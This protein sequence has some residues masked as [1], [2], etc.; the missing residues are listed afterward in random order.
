MIEHGTDEWYEAR[1][2]LITGSR[3]LDVMTSGRSKAEVW[4][5]RALTYALQL[6]TERITGER[7]VSADSAAT[8]HGNVHEAYAIEE[9]ERRT[10]S[11]VHHMGFV[12]KDGMNVGCTPD[13]GVRDV[14]CIEVKCPYNPQNHLGTVLGRGIPKEH[15]PQVQGHLYVTGR[16]WC[17]FISYHPDFPPKT[18]LFVVRA[19]R[20]EA[21]ITQL[22]LRLVE[23]EKLVQK[24]VEDAG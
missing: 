1:L 12:V 6:A 14:G 3:F 18:R 4:G 11:K 15:Y 2:G 23:F 20:D 17:D 13:G 7:H 8:K 19:M 10:F 5:Q 21:F 16:Q 24:L 22:S 9:Y